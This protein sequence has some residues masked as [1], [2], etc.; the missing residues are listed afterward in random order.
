[1]AG[2]K[3]EFWIGRGLRAELGRFM[4]ERKRNAEGRRPLRGA[5]RLDWVGE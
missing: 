3:I 5:L 1:M 4:E 2:G